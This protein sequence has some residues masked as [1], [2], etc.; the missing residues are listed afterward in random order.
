MER[1]RSHPVWEAR[2]DFGSVGV[3]DDADQMPTTPRHRGGRCESGLSE[4]KRFGVGASLFER[5]ENRVH[6]S[7]ALLISPEC[8]VPAGASRPA[9]TPVPS[10]Q[11][12]E[13]HSSASRQ[14]LLHCVHHGLPDEPKKQRKSRFGPLRPRLF[15]GLQ[16]QFRGVKSMDLTVLRKSLG[17]S[18][19]PR[20]GQGRFS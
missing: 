19:P 17:T 2:T 16:A 11:L 1:C 9:G 4:I 14:C 15:S 8:P 3:I 18:H 20:A 7:D 13:P 10:A 5:N 12:L 6:I